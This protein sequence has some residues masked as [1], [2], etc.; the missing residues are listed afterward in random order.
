MAINY[1]RFGKVYCMFEGVLTVFN[2][3]EQGSLVL[4]PP[5]HAQNGNKLF[6]FPKSLLHVWGCFDY[7]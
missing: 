3:V 7:F 2:C 1:L 5:K 6:Q 4:K